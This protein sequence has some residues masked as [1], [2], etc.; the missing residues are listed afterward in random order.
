M[1]K[2]C[3]KPRFR[4][5]IKDEIC[6]RNEPDCGLS[7][8]PAV[9]ETQDIS[10]NPFFAFPASTAVRLGMLAAGALALGTAGIVV[11]G[12]AGKATAVAAPGGGGGGGG[13]TGGGAGG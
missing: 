5:S 11:E 3:G 2:S 4:T 12:I 6:L 7:A 1:Q 10:M 8:S 9:T 13:G